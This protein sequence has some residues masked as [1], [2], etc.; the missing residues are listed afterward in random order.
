[1]LLFQK[2]NRIAS[3]RIFCIAINSS[4]SLNV[5]GKTLQDKEEKRLYHLYGNTHLSPAPVTPTTFWILRSDV[6]LRFLR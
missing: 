1:M 5:H 2:Y 6:Y 3:A 4:F